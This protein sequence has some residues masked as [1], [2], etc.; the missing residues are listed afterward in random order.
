R[1]KTLVM[2]SSSYWLTLLLTIIGQ[3]SGFAKSP[4]FLLPSPVTTDSSHSKNSSALERV[5]QESSSL[6]TTAASSSSGP[7]LVLPYNTLEPGPSHPEGTTAVD[8]GGGGGTKGGGSIYQE[9][10]LRGEWAPI[11]AEAIETIVET[12][13]FIPPELLTHKFISLEEANR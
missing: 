7:R 6:W 2:A 9:T 1:D 13:P 10:S 5:Q 12:G 11:T 8:P 4:S 3:C